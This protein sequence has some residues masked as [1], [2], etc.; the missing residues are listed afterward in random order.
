MVD[1]LRHA[2]IFAII[3]I[4]IAFT[5]AACAPTQLEGKPLSATRT[6]KQ[7]A[8]L[9]VTRSESPPATFTPSM[10]PP[11]TDPYPPLPRSTSQYILPTVVHYPVVPTPVES[12]PLAPLPTPTRL[13]NMTPTSSLPRHRTYP[14]ELISTSP[15]TMWEAYFHSEYKNPPFEDGKPW[16]RWLSIR[17]SSGSPEWIPLD[18]FDPDG[19]GVPIPGT[20]RWDMARQRAYIGMRNNPDGGAFFHGFRSLSR[21]DLISGK[22]TPLFSHKNAYD[23]SVSEDETQ[24]AYILWEARNALY[25]QTLPDSEPTAFKMP[26][27]YPGLGAIVWS[28]NKGQ[29]AFTALDDPFGVP[30]THWFVV[31]LNV[32]DGV[33]TT[34]P[35]DIVSRF[36]TIG[37]VDERT[38]LVEDYEKKQWT[39]NA[40]N[41]DIQP[42]TPTN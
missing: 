23:I 22:L 5:T 30:G 27:S 24:A 13:Q 11:P 42:V 15:D 17:H 33:F 26:Q 18:N 35:V 2:G 40:G 39:L 10:Y 9:A 37:W 3:Q 29:I 14:P 19:Q 25:I 1:K 21:L 12:I 28:P 8:T 4:T 6:P 16:H 41:G 38:I 31:I 20:L 32:M 36:N 34:Y 7:P